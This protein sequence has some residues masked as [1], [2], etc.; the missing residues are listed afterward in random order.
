MPPKKTAPASRDVDDRPV[1]NVHAI[2]I[3]RLWLAALTVGIVAPWLVVAGLYLSTRDRAPDAPAQPVT[4]TTTRSESGRWGTLVTTPIIVS[5][6][7]EYVSGDWGEG[8]T[9]V[10]RFPGASADD[11]RSFLSGSGLSA[12]DVD[13]IVSTATP[14]TGGSGTAVRPSLS[15]VESL[16]PEVRGRLYTQLAH[17]P[18]NENQAMAFRFVGPSPEAWLASRT[19]DNATRAMILPLIYRDG[20]ALFF[21]DFEVVRDRVT[22]AAQRVRLMRALL[23]HATVIVRLSVD[24][25]EDIDRLA[26]Y[27]GTGGRRTDLWPLLESVAGAGSDRSIDITHLLP[28]FAR[29]H[30]YR[31]PKLTTADLDLPL[32]AN[33]LWTALNFFREEPDDRFLDVSESLRTLRQDYY[34]VE[35]EFQLGDV[36]VWVDEDGNLFHAAVYLA[37]DLVFSKNG[38]SPMA[39]WTIMSI[40]DVERFYATRSEHPQR[41]YHRRKDL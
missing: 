11:V 8:S 13:R 10:W 2:A 4:A 35:Q 3:P 39:P 9:P 6:P 15:T 30:L 32:M 27:W 5:P 33:C 20:G 28:P 26:A 23:R 22:D 38:T 16:A 18:A 31:Y 17:A 37:D 7:I 29:N 1:R 21:S 41:I 14:M 25:T 12:A 34:V 19:L 24:S 40:P 36:I